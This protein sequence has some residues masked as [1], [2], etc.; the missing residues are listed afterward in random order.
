MSTGIR[1]PLEW[2]EEY[3]QKW[4]D[5]LRPFC[6]RVEFAGSIR[7]RKPEVGDIE[8][9]CVPG[10]DINRVM[11]L[12]NLLRHAPKVKGKPPHMG[13]KY[14]Q[15]VL[16]APSL[17]LD[18]FFCTPENWGLNYT[19]RTGSADFTHALATHSSNRGYIWHEARVYSAGAF[20]DDPKEKRPDGAPYELPEEADVFR[21]FGVEWVKPEDRTDAAAL[22]R[23]IRPGT[24]G[25]MK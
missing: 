4:L 12:H 23:A 22:K 6:D 20:G 19:I 9:C 2:A 10:T 15:L 16:M 21:F 1:I 8:I 7:R 14:M 18:L 13:G 5:R 24:P 3:G 11:G 17:K 25:R